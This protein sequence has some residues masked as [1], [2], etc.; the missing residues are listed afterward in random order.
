MRS[1]LWFVLAVGL[2]ALGF[3]Y[4]EQNGIT[5]ANLNALDT[6]SLTVKVITLAVLAVIVI[7]LFLLAASL[8]FLVS[9]V[10]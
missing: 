4:L 1:L 3:I 9:L 7:G 8:R 10:A 5:V 6:S 2:V